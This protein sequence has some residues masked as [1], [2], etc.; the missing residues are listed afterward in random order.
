MTTWEARDRD[1]F[2]KTVG[3]ADDPVAIDWMESDPRELEYIDFTKDPKSMRAGD[4]LVYYAAVHQKLYG[5]V[6]ISSRSSMDAQKRRWPYY[7]K[8]SPKLVIRDMDRAPSIDTL[9]MPDRN[10]RKL[11]QR[12]DYMKLSSSEYERALAA[13]DEACDTMLGDVRDP[14][15]NR[16][17]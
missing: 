11:V 15:F 7:A 17:R 12:R 14:H 9:T 16:V 5:I 6:E 1:K 4:Y 10:F 2:L 13:I 3:T 8:V